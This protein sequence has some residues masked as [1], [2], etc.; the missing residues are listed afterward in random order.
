MP[1]KIQLTSL[2]LALLMTLGGAAGAK[3]SVNS[4]KASVSKISAMVKIIL[5]DLHSI[6]NHGDKS[7]P[8]MY[9]YDI[10]RRLLDAK[11]MFDLKHYDKAA[12]LFSALVDN[13]IALAVGM[14]AFA[15]Q[16]SVA[17]S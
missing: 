17:G 10:E 6:R 8:K 16:V 2:L 9:T 13:P 5:A 11:L 12:I 1:V 4:T 7:A 3:P 14:P 15:V